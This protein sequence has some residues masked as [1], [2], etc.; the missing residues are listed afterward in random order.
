LYRNA[1]F[2]RDERDAVALL[3]AVAMNVELRH[4]SVGCSSAKD[5]SLLL[6]E[7]VRLTG[8]LGAARS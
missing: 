3:A 5:P 8:R 4:Y 2:D 1:E 7:R 6:I